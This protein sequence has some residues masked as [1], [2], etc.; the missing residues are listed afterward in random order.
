MG[1]SRGIGIEF[2]HQLVWDDFKRRLDV[3]WH[4]SQSSAPDNVV[5]A[6]VR[7]VAGAT[8][9]QALASSASNIHILQGNLSD[10]KSLNAS[11]NIAM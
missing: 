5:F 4:N 3:Q 8:A 6:I 10:Y 7:N 9:L 11:P 2:V 1:A